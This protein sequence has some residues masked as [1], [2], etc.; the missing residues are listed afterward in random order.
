MKEVQ[1]VQANGF[2]IFSG[3]ANANSC[4]IEKIGHAKQFLIYANY[5]LKGHLKIFDYVINR[6]GWVMVVKIMK[7]ES[8]QEI[9]GD[10]VWRRVSERMRLLLSTFVRVTNKQKGRT[11]CLVHSSF[12]RYRFE[13]LDEAMIYLE[14]I[15]NK[16]FRLYAG[17]KKY[18]GLKT[19][20]KIDKKVRNGSIFLCSKDVGKVKRRFFVER[21]VF[22]F[23]DLRKLVVKNMIKNTK[24]FHSPPT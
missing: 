5:F 7:S 19:H 4:F 6:D 8:N 12:K 1:N 2:Y 3:R 24:N 14:K 23:I 13:R 15:R 21:E 10:E 22:E 17:R 16:N 11:G 20:Y 18:R 9:T